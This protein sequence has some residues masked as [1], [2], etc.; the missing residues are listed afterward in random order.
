MFHGQAR[1]AVVALVVGLALAAGGATAATKRSVGKVWLIKEKAFERLEQA[2]NWEDLFIDDTIILDQ[3]VRTPSDA[4]LHVR[5]VDGTELRL[6]AN[7][8]L[9]INR[10]VFD[11]SGKSASE[12]SFTFVSGMSRVITDQV[13]K[14]DIQTP[15]ATIGI[16]GSDV[17][18]AQLQDLGTVIQVNQGQ[19]SLT[20]CSILGTQMSFAA[21]C[22]GARRVMVLAGQSAGVTPGFALAMGTELPFEDPGL[23]PDGGLL[24]IEP[25]SGRGGPPIPGSSRSN[26]PENP[27]LNREFLDLTVETTGVLSTA[28][29]DFE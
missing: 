14:V 19:V 7:A 25:A 8:E 4:A 28:E 5:F 2:S 1:K 16:R 15:T 22:G 24:D 6:G 20:A 12:L 3:W 17:I 23:R 27:N 29:P 18:V 9:L 10:Y 26:E 11:P 21:R 13:K